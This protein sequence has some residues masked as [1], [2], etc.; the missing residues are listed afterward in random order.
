MLPWGVRE[1][2]RASSQEECTFFIPAYGWPTAS[3]DSKQSV[4]DTKLL[5]VNIDEF[6]KFL[7]WFFFLREKDYTN[8]YCLTNWVMG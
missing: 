6:F 2:G 8:A 1:L 4:K 5:F 3:G 7:F